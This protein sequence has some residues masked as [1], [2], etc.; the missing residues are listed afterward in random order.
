[1]DGSNV[2]ENGSEKL[3]ELLVDVFE[4]RT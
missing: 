3:T 1:L 2:A 4:E